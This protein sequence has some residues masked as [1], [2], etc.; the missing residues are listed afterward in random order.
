[1]TRIFQGTWKEWVLFIKT[2]GNKTLGELA[3]ELSKW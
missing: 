3:K 2:H 1:M